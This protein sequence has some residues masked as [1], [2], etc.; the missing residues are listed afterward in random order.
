MAFAIIFS[1]S[2]QVLGIHVEKLDMGVDS[3]LNFLP[4]IQSGLNFVASHPC[5]YTSDVQVHFWEERG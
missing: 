5:D 4:V 2:P 3:L 1:E